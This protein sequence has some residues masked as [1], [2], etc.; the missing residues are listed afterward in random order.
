MEVK[1]VKKDILFSIFLIWGR[2]A[3]IIFGFNNTWFRYHLIYQNHEMQ[4]SGAMSIGLMVK[5]TDSQLY[6]S[7]LFTY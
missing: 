1:K 2:G 3:V 4:L 6:F 7:Q 5:W